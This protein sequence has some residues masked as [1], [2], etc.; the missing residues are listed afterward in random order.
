MGDD[1]ESLAMLQACTALR[2]GPGHEYLVLG[3]MLAPAQVET[4]TVRWQQEQIMHAVPAVFDAAWQSP[5]GTFGLVL[6]N[7]T[8]QQQTVTVT[9]ARL[10]AAVRVHMANSS[11]TSSSR[12]LNQE[13]LT[14]SL[15]P[16]SCALIENS[17]ETA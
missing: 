1:E 7:W 6:A 12:D 15:P 2:R 11:V 17:T 16:L 10:G 13:L 8:Q 14:I 5:D 9:D 4:Q 3:R